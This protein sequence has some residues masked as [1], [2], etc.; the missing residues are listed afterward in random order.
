MYVICLEGE[1]FHHE[2]KNVLM[3]IYKR[4]SAKVEYN[5]KKMELLLDV[6]AEI[7]SKIQ[8]EDNW[9]FKNASR[10]ELETNDELMETKFLS[11]MNKKDRNSYLYYKNNDYQDLPSYNICKSKPARKA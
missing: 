3:N 8:F 2:D 7:E 11:R 10:W 5:N 1:F 6:F 9:M 4:R